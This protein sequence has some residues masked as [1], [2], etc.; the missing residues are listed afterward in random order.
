MKTDQVI[1]VKQSNA[2]VPPDVLRSE[3]P[4]QLFTQVPAEALGINFKHTENDFIDN[5][6]VD[7]MMG[8]KTRGS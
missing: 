1:T 3:S 5:E 2:I 6:Y 7:L 8:S 4:K